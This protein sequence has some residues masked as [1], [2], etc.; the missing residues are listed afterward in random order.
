MATVETHGFNADTAAGAPPPPSAA[1][2]FLAWVQLRATQ[3]GLA[4]LGGLGLGLFLLL[5]TSAHHHS[6]HR[7]DLRTVVIAIALMVGPAAMASA[8]WTVMSALPRARRG[9]VD[10]PLEVLLCAS[11]TRGRF[12]LDSASLWRKDGEGP[13]LI[14]EFGRSLWS[15]PFKLQ[16]QMTPAWAYAMP[17]KGEFV[18]VVFEG[19]GLVARIR[20]TDSA[21]P[22]VSRQAA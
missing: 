6:S 3:M 8:A 20:R 13:Q 1:R 12:A 11:I 10:Q 15:R 7:A 21:S 22:V 14:A 19:G 5:F 17:V 16:A 9:L 4:G 2:D 18:T